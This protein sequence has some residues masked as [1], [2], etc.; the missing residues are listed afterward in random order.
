MFARHF[1][2]KTL[3]F[4]SLLLLVAAP[5]LGCSHSSATPATPSAASASTSGAPKAELASLV[6]AG[7]QWTAALYEGRTQE[8]WDHLGTGLRQSFKDKAGLDGFCTE[9]RKELGAESSV[10]E[11]RTETVQGTTAY[12]RIAR[13]ERA[14]MPI[15][16]VFG[17]DGDGTIVLFGIRAEGS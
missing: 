16:V 15:R 13:F 2:S 3:S 1:V 11:E 8:M 7:R 17:F 12:V 9:A 6:S 4:S 14:P 5:G 10:V